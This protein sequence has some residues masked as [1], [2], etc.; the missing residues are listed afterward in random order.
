[1]GDTRVKWSKKILI[2]GGL[3]YIGSHLVKSLTERGQFLID[4]IDRDVSNQPN[5]EFV[6]ER[7]N[8][9]IDLDLVDLKDGAW[10]W[11]TYD[12]IVHLGALISVGESVKQ[13]VDYWINNLLSTEKLL[14]HVAPQTHLIFASTGTAFCP[15]NPYAY[16]KVACERR[17]IDRA[18]ETKFGYTIFRFFNVSGLCDGIKPTGEATHLIRRAAMAAHGLSGF[19]IMGDQWETPDGTAIR[20]YIHVEDIANSIV[21]AIEQ[22]PANTPYECLGTGKG[23][24]VK[25]VVESM[26]KVSGVDF[27]V[28]IG[29]A[30][31][32]DVAKMICDSQ[33]KHISLSHDLDSMCLSAF[34]N[35]K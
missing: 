30:R 3:G 21:N 25:E 15:E 32:G 29:A 1:M 22:G 8:E 10:R 24:S 16:S 5:Y 18:A 2:T 4:I 19:S 12:A 6:N 33:Y 31:E 26:K 17:I 34:K 27:E 35:I 20:D 23:Y 7:V 9:I 14:D 28:Q 11:A 13:P